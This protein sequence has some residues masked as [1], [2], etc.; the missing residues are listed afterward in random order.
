MQAELNRIHDKPGVPPPPKKDSTASPTT[1]SSTGTTGSGQPSS[2]SG[3]GGTST[4]DAITIKGKEKAYAKAIEVLTA[5]LKAANLKEATITSGRRTAAEQAADMYNNLVGTGK[6]QGLVAQR[7]LYG[8]N[9]N[10]V[11]D[12]YVINKN[13]PKDQVI[14]AMTDAIDG[15]GPATVSKHCGSGAID[16]APASI[17]DQAAFTK[18]ARANTDVKRFLTPDQNDDPVF[19]LEIPQS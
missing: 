1:P 14:K 9:G 2:P 12:V 15:L 11:I 6:N 4:T 17:K 19:H 13:R 8:P 10:K 5:I 16:V 18:A 3:S 7:R